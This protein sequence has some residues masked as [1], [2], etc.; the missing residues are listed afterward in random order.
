MIPAILDLLRY[1]GITPLIVDLVPPGS[2]RGQGNFNPASY[3]TMFDNVFHL[4]IEEDGGTYQPFLRILKS[5]ANDF[6]RK[7]IPIDYQRK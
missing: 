2:A 1:R 6:S 3:I 5:T 7:P 4:Y